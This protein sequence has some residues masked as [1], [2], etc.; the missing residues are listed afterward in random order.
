MTRRLNSK[1]LLTS[2]DFR[3]THPELRI[4]G[5]F[6]PGAARVGDQIVLLVRV[7]QGCTREKSGWLYS[8]RS[9]LEEGRVVY[10]IDCL[11]VHARDGARDHRKPLL[12]NGRRRLAF[13]SHL[14]IVHLGADGYSVERIAPHDELFGRTDDEEYG[15]EDPRITKIGDTYYITYVSVSSRMG[16][17]TSLMS[18]EDFRSFQRHGIIFPCENKDVVLFPEQ[19]ADRYCAFHRPVG[20]IHI[21]P[22]AV[23]AACSPDLLHWGGHVHVLGCPDDGGWYSAR[24]GA[25]PPPL[26]TAE[27]W[28]S[29]FHGVRKRWPDDPIGEYT[30]GAMLTALENPARLIAVSP[31]PFFRAEEPYELSG[32]VSHVVFP[33]GLVTDLDDPDKVHVYYGCADSSVAVSTFSV[34]EIMASLR[35]V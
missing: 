21:R 33:T 11:K 13:I 18:T 31:D 17:S 5:A 1:C 32:Y 35:R 12:E 34:R 4:V 22:L 24:I 28:L 2:D 29:L 25:G 6:N 27:G 16:V 3:A 26:K 15:V 9:R 7:A 8:P 20:H 30:G 14:E 19:V 23:V 10:E